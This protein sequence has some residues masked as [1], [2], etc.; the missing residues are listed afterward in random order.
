M[1][2]VLAFDS[3]K[4][5][6]SA[7]AACAAAAAGIRRHFPGMKVV[8]CPLSDGGE[9]FVAA[10]ARATGGE[11]RTAQVTGPLFE[12]VEARY[13]VLPAAVGTAVGL[14]EWTAAPSA[15]DV[16]VLECA[17]V[18]GLELVPPDKRNPLETTTLGL[19]QLVNKLAVA[20]LHRLVIGL[21]GSATNDGGLGMLSAMAWR[22][23]DEAGQLVHPAG[24]GLGAV[25]RLV[26]DKWPGLPRVV[27]ACDV[28]NP[29]CG[30]DGA[31]AVYS[32]Q[33]GATPDQVAEL[34]AG[35]RNLA[36]V[37]AQHLGR[38]YSRAPGAGAA[39]GLGF[40]LQAFLGATFVPGAELAMQLC[41]LDEKLAGASLCITGEGRTD[42]QTACGK[43]PAAVAAACARHGVPC[44]CLSGSLGPGWQALLD[45]GFTSMFS[46]SPGPQ[47]LEQALAAAEPALA[48][49]AAGVARLYAAGRKHEIRK[50]KSAGNSELQT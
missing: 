18:C 46:I 42:S 28:R 38:D 32:P 16:A 49:A 26:G 22:F 5:C 24:S 15:Q 25:R 50:T 14:S 1:K 31:A 2:I 9:G 17:Q 3:F 37:A 41:G 40:A 35:L 11:V 30:P 34:D 29:L 7:P 39:G 23:Q 27:A 20:G 13:V 8:E 4:G 43:L 33:K 19:G 45:A 21:G 48:D 12:P 44:V 36:A 6:L 47:S 10:I